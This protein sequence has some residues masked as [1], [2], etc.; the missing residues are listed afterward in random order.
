MKLMIILIS[1]LISAMASAQ[2]QTIQRYDHQTGQWTTYQVTPQGS[3]QQYGVTRFDQGYGPPQYRTY[4]FD[5]PAQP[6][7]Q[8]QPQAI[9]PQRPNWKYRR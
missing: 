7:R 4:T 8:I 5:Q 9:P 6:R 2:T 1:L 3:R